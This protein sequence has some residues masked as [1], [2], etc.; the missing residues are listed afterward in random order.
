M[1]VKS[2]T[3]NFTEIRMAVAAMIHAGG[4]INGPKNDE[5]NSHY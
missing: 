5:A 4:R 2:P 1:F 3:L